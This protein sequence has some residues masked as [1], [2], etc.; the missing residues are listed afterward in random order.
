ML[1]RAIPLARSKQNLLSHV[2]GTSEAMPRRSVRWN[3]LTRGD[4]GS[5]RMHRLGPVESH[6]RFYA[7]DGMW[8]MSNAKLDD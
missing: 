8:Y 7:Y 4:A 1:S 3:G 2:T 6:G 5:R